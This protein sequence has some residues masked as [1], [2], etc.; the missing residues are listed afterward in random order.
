VPDRTVNQGVSRTLMVPSPDVL[1][2]AVAVQSAAIRS[3]PSWWSSFVHPACTNEQRMTVTDGHQRSIWDLGRWRSP[4]AFA[5][6]S[7]LVRG[8]RCGGQGRGRTADL[9]L[10]RLAVQKRRD[11]TRNIPWQAGAARELRRYWPQATSLG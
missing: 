3:L 10:F 6:V 2:W 5:Q 7:E 8:L 4:T 1:T 9:P 11:P